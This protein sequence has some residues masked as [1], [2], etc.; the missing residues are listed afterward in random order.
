MGLSGDRNYARYHHVLNRAVW[1]PIHVSRVLLRCCVWTLTGETLERRQ[2]PQLNALG[3][4]RHAVRSSRS[5]MVEAS[6]LR[7]V[8]LMWL[9]HV[10]WA[11]RHWALPFL[12]VLSPS[13]RCYQLRGRTHP[14]EAPRPGP[15]DSLTTPLTHFWQSLQELVTLIPRLF[16]P[17]PARS[18][19]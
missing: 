2:G 13:K 1:S 9:G 16:A 3:I 12:T 17:A 15:S 6:V 19:G 7:W 5:Y 14:Q 11:G 8:S 18:P 4:Y 10:P